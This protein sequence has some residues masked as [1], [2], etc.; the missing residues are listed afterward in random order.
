MDEKIKVFDNFLDTENILKIKRYL[1][2]AEY[3]C[4]CLNDQNSCLKKDIPYWRRDLTTEEYFSVSLK[5]E[6]CEQTNITIK[7]NRVYLIFFYILWI[8]Q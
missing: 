8:L 4:N 2:R 3:A 1:R 6:I 7:L 5:N